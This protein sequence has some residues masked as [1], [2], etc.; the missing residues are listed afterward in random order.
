[1]VN[2]WTS[3]TMSFYYEFCGICDLLWYSS[4]TLIMHLNFFK[5]FLYFVIN[6]YSSILILKVLHVKRFLVISVTISFGK[7][8]R[9]G[10]AGLPY[11]LPSKFILNY[12]SFDSSQREKKEY[13]REIL[14]WRSYQKLWGFKVTKKQQGGP[15]SKKNQRKI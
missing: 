2:E 15:L 7:K 12:S 14:R 1:M 3:K 10:W 4:K 13:V 11:S 9:G 6:F 8:I 5:L